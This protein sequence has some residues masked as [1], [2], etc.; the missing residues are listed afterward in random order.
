MSEPLPPVPT[1]L[2]RTTKDGTKV[3]YTI[4][5]KMGSGGFATVYSGEEMPGRLPVA[6]KCISQTRVAD[7][8]V[9]RKLISEVDIHKSLHHQNI[10][11]FKGVFQDENYVYILLELCP[12]GTILD[13]LKKQNPFSEKQTSQ[14]CFQLLN[15][16]VYLHEHRVIHRDLKLQN[17]LLDKNNHMKLADFGL[18]AQLQSDDEKKMTICGT[19]SYLSPEVV[20]GGKKGH[21]TSVDIWATGVCS[22]LMLTGKQPF[23]SSDKKITYKKISHVNY[24]WPEKPHVSELAKDFVDH[25]LQ[26]DPEARPTAK[27]L[28][29]H[30]FIT[31]YNAEFIQSQNLASTVTNSTLDSSR[32]LLMTSRPDNSSTASE[33]EEANENQESGQPLRLPSYSVRIWWDYSHRYGLAYMLH[34]H[35]CGACFNDSSRILLSPDGTFCQYWATQQTPAPDIVDMSTIE[36]SPIRK[37]LLL[38]QHF[39]VELRQRAGAMHYPPIEITS[40]TMTIPHVKYWARTRDGVLFRMANRDIQAN[41]R[42]HTKLVIESNSKNLFYDTGRGVQQLTLADLGD[43]ERYHEVRKR[44]VI[45]KEMAKELV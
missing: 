23:Q 42:D 2:H 43:R 35:I 29:T 25:A 24:S 11:E 34:N 14:I 41:F 45:V 33:N 28:L 9:R 7:P 17:L 20:G 12:N 10:V 3:T 32:N 16:L 37:K 5:E 15:A 13:M 30:P 44:F 38:I 36:G 26:K 18:S 8:K 40:Q 1:V 31:T 4:K 22:F 27:E 39:A 21:T 6:I 19:P